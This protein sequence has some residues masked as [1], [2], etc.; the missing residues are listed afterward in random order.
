ME[1]DKDVIIAGLKQH[2][3]TLQHQLEETTIMLEVANERWVEQVNKNTQLEVKVR[4]K[5]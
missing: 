2:V 5:G 3:E 4:K 1:E